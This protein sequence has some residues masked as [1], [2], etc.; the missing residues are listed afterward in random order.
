MADLDELLHRRRLLRAHS[1]VDP[2]L[3]L[4]RAADR[5]TVTP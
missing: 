5:E 4:F 2:E 3:H 1:V